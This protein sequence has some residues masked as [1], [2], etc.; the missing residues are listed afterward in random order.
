MKI[1]LPVSKRDFHLLDAQTRLEEH[2]DSL[3][4]FDVVFSP[5]VDVMAQLQTSDFIERFQNIT[6]STTVLDVGYTETGSWPDGP[7]K[8]WAKT[9]YTMFNQYGDEEWFWKELDC[10]SVMQNWAVRINEEFITGKKP[11]MGCIVKTP[12]KD[13]KVREDDEM[14]MGCAVYKGGFASAW[15]FRPILDFF[16]NGKSAQDQEGDPWDLMAR[17]AFKK[18]G[19][20]P[21]DLIGDRWN[22]QNFR[23]E[24]GRLECD[25]G[26]T[27]YENIAHK[28]ADLS[29]AVVIHGCKDDSLARLVL[30]GQYGNFLN[31]AK[32]T[33]SV[34]QRF[35]GY[36]PP[37]PKE[38]LELLLGRSVSDE[39]Q[40][41]MVKALERLISPEPFQKIDAQGIVNTLKVMKMVS[42]MEASS[43]TKLSSTE[44]LTLL[45]SSTKSLRLTELARQSQWEQKELEDLL[46][47]NGY[48][49]MPKLLWIKKAKD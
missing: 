30:S 4:V 36:T 42:G 26:P 8:H 19:W 44:V 49:V 39:E 27:V 32:R 41:N 40:V 47:A 15:D 45:E 12:F 31:A 9:A 33:E 13:K 38:A 24:N 29:K 10:W 48:Q 22:T 17:G 14:M 6:R 28:S 16:I 7:N 46:K 2:L 25:A 5:S 1:V 37:T 18:R 3:R 35:S 11:F 23:V 34:S 20:T 21:T 43:D